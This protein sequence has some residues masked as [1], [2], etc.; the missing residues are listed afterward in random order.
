MVVAELIEHVTSDLR[1]SYVQEMFC[2]IETKVVLD[3]RDCVFVRRGEL[4]ENAMRYLRF[5]EVKRGVHAGESGSE[6]RYRC[7]SALHFS[8]SRIPIRAVVDVDFE[9]HGQRVDTLHG[10]LDLV[11][12]RFNLVERYFED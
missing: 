9:R 8:V 7:P 1:I 4:F 6:N 2:A 12:R 10:S 11:L 3:D 5:F